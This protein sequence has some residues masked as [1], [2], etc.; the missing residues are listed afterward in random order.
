MTKG[1]SKSIKMRYHNNYCMYKNIFCG[2]DYWKQSD[3][4]YGT[5]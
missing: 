1:L 4:S 2:G 3:L 5:Q